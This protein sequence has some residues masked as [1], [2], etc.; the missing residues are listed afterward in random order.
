MSDVRIMSCCTTH[1]WYFPYD[2]EYYVLFNNFIFKVSNT[3]YDSRIA[4]RGTGNGGPECRNFAGHPWCR[5]W[6]GS[7]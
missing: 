4:N 3:N 1:E 7:R 5:A 2:Y 6:I